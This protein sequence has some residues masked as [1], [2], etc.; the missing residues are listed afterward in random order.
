MQDSLLQYIEKYE[1]VRVGGEP[2]VHYGRGK[3]GGWYHVL[4][5]SLYVSSIAATSVA[6]SGYL[7]GVCKEQKSYNN[8]FS[9]HSHHQNIPLLTNS[10]VTHSEE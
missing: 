5:I 2:M 9:L 8:P 1:E 7:M 3:S 10:A 4:L 6:K